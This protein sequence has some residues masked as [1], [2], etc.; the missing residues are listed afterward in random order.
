MPNERYIQGISV[1]INPQNE[2]HLVAAT[3]QGIFVSHD[4]GRNFINHLDPRTIDD[5]VI[6]FQFDPENPDLLF[7]VTPG[8]ILLSE[9]AGKNFEPALSTEAEIL[10]L[11]LSPT[12][13]LISTTDGLQIAGSESLE[14]ILKGHRIVGS[15]P[16]KNDT[17]LALSDKQLFFI[18]KDK[19]TH[20]VLNTSSNDPFIKIDGDEDMAW[21]L[22]PSTLLRVGE[23]MPYNDKGNHIAPTLSMSLDQVEKEVRSF[24][25]VEIEGER[26][27]HT[28]WYSQ[29]LPDLE[30]NVKGGL[31]Q[32]TRL[33]FDGVFPARFF[34]AEAYAQSNWGWEVMAKWDLS[35]FI[36][37]DR[38]NVVHHEMILES[39]MR[40]GLAMVLNNIRAH[41]REASILTQRLQKKLSDE[42]LEFMWRMRLE[43][44]GAYL[45]TMSGKKIVLNNSLEPK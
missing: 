40:D 26:Y 16:W 12:A 44:I 35:Q 3:D 17:I 10:H 28:R 37:G 7:A 38:S 13:A 22:T 21:I 33:L 2:K 9:D 27:L 25:K 18:D 29:M 15:V 23:S 4:G 5:Y 32:R 14:T 30:M 6:K 36:F 41:Y 11:S 8:V 31:S 39:S 42:R 45:H 1:A 24:Q 43:E 34:F 19:K 20:I